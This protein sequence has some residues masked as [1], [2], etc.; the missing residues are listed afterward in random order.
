MHENPKPESVTT[1]AMPAATVA[2]TAM[3]TIATVPS[4]PAVAMTM[5]PIRRAHQGDCRARA[6]PSQVSRVDRPS[7]TA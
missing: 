6:T 3:A 5:P 7:I 4:V 1:A 2:S